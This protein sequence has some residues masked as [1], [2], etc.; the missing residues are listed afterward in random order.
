MTLGNARFAQ[1]F[2][3]GRGFMS[4]RA[5]KF[6]VRERHT[7]GAKAEGIRAKRVVLRREFRLRDRRGVALRKRWRWSYYR[8][9]L[10][11]S[12]RSN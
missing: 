1:T 5:L 7:C 6:A 2:T 9:Q 4:V 3:G 8:R 10:R 11:L 12:M